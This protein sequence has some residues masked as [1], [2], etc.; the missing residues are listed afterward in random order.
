MSIKQTDGG[1]PPALH[2]VPGTNHDLHSIR[3]C[4]TVPPTVLVTELDN[5]A[6][7]LHGRPDGPR[8][9]LSPADA[10][11]LRREL[12]AAFERTEL[13]QRSRQG[14]SL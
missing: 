3:P 12:A 6:M 1:K 5:G 14:E 10:I 2:P 11:P 4:T 8:V 9:Y 7:I 13:A